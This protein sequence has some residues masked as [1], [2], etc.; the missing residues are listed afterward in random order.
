MMNNITPGILNKSELCFIL[1][2][3]I[4]QKSMLSG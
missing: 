2:M 4:L 3:Q 1:N